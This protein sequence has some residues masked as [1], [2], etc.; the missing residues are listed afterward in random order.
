M[1]SVRAAVAQKSDHVVDG[2]WSDDDLRN[3]AIRAG[4]GGVAD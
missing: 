2:A 3:E 4:I 1:T